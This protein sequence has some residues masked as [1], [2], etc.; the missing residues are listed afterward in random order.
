M[1]SVVRWPPSV[2]I[3]EGAFLD[4]FAV[5]AIYGKT[6]YMPNIVTIDGIPVYQALVDGQD[7]GMLRISLVDD[8]AVQSNFLAFSAQH[9][10]RVQTYAVADEE[11]RLVLGVVMRADFP[12]YRR[13][14]QAD[15]SEL[16]FYIIYKADTIRAMAEK[17]LAE[18]R[19]N[20]VNLM[21]E[22]GSDV[23]GV[24]MVQYFIKGAGIAPEGFEGIADGSLFAEFHI[25]NDEVWDAVKAG[26]YRGFSLEGI[27]DLVPERDKTSVQEIVDTLDGVFSKINPNYNNMTKVKGLLARLAEALAEKEAKVKMGSVSTDK[28]VLAWDGEEDL[29]VGDN[30]YSVDAEGNRAPIEDGVYTTG[31]GKTI[32]VVDGKV[33]A[34]TDPKA[35]VAPAEPVEQAEEPAAAPAEQVSKKNTDKGEIEWDGSEDLKEG[36]AVFVRDAEGNRVP[37]A[38]GD[39]VTEDGKTISVV[40]GKVA[41]IA[42]PAAEVAPIVEQT[43]FQRIAQ[44][45]AETYEDKMKKIYDAI[46]E[47][48]YDPYGW[49]VEA[50]DEYAIY[51]V[52]NE[53][54]RFTIKEWDDEGNPV[55]ENGVKVV[56]AF[57]TPEEKEKADEEFA[58]AKREVEELRAQVETLSKTPAASPA[59]DEFEKQAEVQKTGNKGLD[60]LARVARAK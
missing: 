59:H 45:F 17:Y 47:M 29:K 43:A 41:S 42:D 26:T 40:D 36:D 27:F 8:P 18:N 12:I 33:A 34:L 19:Q 32:E 53:F 30:V 10:S 31:D 20:L 7:C 1:L 28:G 6:A 13:E 21:H 58:A 15:G 16:E 56:P 25:T 54:Y 38:D 57:V 24:Q 37:A 35:E 4:T 2:E 23:E 60:R 5:P 51:A 44:A 52:G 46:K 48:G 49:L 14:K 50:G 22:D 3:R 11:K 9:P 55:L 39:Y